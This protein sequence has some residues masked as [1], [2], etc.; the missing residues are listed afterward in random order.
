MSI[1]RK[2]LLAGVS[3]AA[4]ALVASMVTVAAPANAAAKCAPYA[5][6]HGIKGK[7]V[8]VFTSILD[9]ELSKLKLA[10]AGFI[11]CTGVNVK[12]EGSNQFEALLPVRVRGGNA[13]DIALI[14]QP[15]LLAAMVATGKVKPAPAG[16]IANITKSTVHHGRHSDR[17]RVS[18]TPPRL[19]PT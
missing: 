4:L 19:A 15:G 9:P 6:Y 16:V 2:S 7:T 11:K 3:T 1:S 13:P 10:M 17:L 18:S 5:S 12:F 8:K 14:P